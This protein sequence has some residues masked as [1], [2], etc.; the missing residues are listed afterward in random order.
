MDVLIRFN[1]GN[2]LSIILLIDLFR[3]SVP[4]A[5][6]TLRESEFLKVFWA[7]MPRKMQNIIIVSFRSLARL[8]VYLLIPEALRFG[9]W[10]RVFYLAAQAR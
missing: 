7:S 3:Q 9:D 8:K 2:R 10:L 4:I 5:A 1:A 6:N